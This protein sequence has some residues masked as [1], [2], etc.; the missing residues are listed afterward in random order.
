MKIL[1][2]KCP[3]CGSLKIS[4]NIGE[5]V[6]KKCGFVLDENIVVGC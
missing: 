1:K 5:N 4:R 6:C 2:S 3:E